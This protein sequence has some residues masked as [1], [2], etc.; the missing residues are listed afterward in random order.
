MCGTINPT[1]AIGPTK[2]EIIPVSIAVEII[3]KYFD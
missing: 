3:I 2:A 1:K